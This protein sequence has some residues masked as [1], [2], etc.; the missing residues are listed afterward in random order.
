[1]PFS[2]YSLRKEQNT[3]CDKDL[4]HVIKNMQN[5]VSIWAVIFSEGK[6]DQHV[7]T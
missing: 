4:C 3:D 2:V 5:G 1:M 7:V 6:N